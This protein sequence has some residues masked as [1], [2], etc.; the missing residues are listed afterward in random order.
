MSI[1][2]SNNF[3]RIFAV[4]LMLMFVAQFFAFI[5]PAFAQTPDDPP[6]PSACAIFST[7][8]ALLPD[9]P[10]AILEFLDAMVNGAIEYILG[11][12]QS[13]ATSLIDANTHKL[14]NLPVIT[15]GWIQTRDIAN[16]FFVFILLW[17]A[18]ATIFDVQEYSAKRLLPRFIIAALLI[19]FSLPIGKTVVALGN[20]FAAVFYPKNL[21]GAIGRLNEN[22]YIG[23]KVD[24]V[25]LSGQPTSKNPIDVVTLIRTKLTKTATVDGITSTITYPECEARKKWREANVAGVNLA[26][27]TGVN[28]VIDWYQGTT[29]VEA[30]NDAA[31]GKMEGTAKAAFDKFSADPTNKQ[32]FYKIYGSQIVAKAFMGILA[33]FVMGALCVMLVIRYVSLIFILILG[34]FAFLGMILPKTQQWW[35]QWWE[36]LIKWTFFLPAFVIF[37]KITIGMIN[38]INAQ[39]ANAAQAGNAGF[40]EMLFNQLIAGSMLIGSLMAAQKMGIETADAAMNLGKKWAMNTKDTLKRGALAVPRYGMRR[41]DEAAGG[42]ASKIA[43]GLQDSWIGKTKLGSHALADIEVATKDRSD[44][45]FNERFGASIKGGSD[46][47][48]INMAR[49]YD[50]KTAQKIIEQRIKSKGADNWSNALNNQSSGDKTALGRKLATI[51]AG[52]LV[53]DHTNNPAEYVDGMM[54]NLSSTMNNTTL[55]QTVRDKARKDRQELI[56]QKMASLNN[57]SAEFVQSMD[58]ETAKLMT[59]EQIQQTCSTREGATAWS[60]TYKRLKAAEPPALQRFKDAYLSKFAEIETEEYEK[61]INEATDGVPGRASSQLMQNARNKAQQS[62]HTSAHSHATKIVSAPTFLNEKTQGIMNAIPGQIILSGGMLK[63]QKGDYDKL[64]EQIRRDQEQQNKNQE[65]AAN[66]SQTKP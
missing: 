15:A 31:C 12:V 4:M 36:A 54:P 29:K 66:Q 61:L 19:N 17:I 24:S 27:V 18:L 57:L 51:G 21:S 13:V 45:R 26:N 55:P 25:Q 16:I 40:F 63:K 34:P 38:M 49:Q 32:R 28:F 9:I 52:S 64:L 62:A 60:S 39:Y 47:S 50:A 6:P 5:P 65:G 44:K 56:K 53:Y 33:V 10:C 22:A 59:A 8:N 43:K 58:A 23:M 35:N 41:A 48:L 20:N 42:K 46:E 11:G 2:S 14:T 3:K 37:L 7:A 1:S 30:A